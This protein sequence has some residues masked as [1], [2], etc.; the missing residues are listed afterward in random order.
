MI[1]SENLKRES[2][3]VVRYYGSMTVYRC[4]TSN[5]IINTYTNRQFY[6]EQPN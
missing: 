1:Q 6:E 2:G 5:I 4:C 3:R